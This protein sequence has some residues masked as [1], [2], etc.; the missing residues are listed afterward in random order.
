M[1]E[2]HRNKD[3]TLTAWFKVNAQSEACRDIL[4]QDFPSKMVWKDR[5]H[6]W[7]PREPGTFSISRMYH[8]HPTSGEHFYLRLLLTCTKGATSFEDLC[9]VDGVH[10]D[11][12]KEAC[13]LHGLVDDDREW[14]QCLTEA[15]DMAVGWQ[16]RHLFVSIL[17]DCTPSRPRELWDTFWPHICDDL[18]CQL[19]QWGMEHH[20]M[21]RCRTMASISLTNL[22]FTLVGGLRSGTGSRYL[23]ITL[24]WSRGTMT[25]MH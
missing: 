22:S 2:S 13:F 8:A 15:K 20:L 24:L 3:T 16:L 11:T 18:K 14:H 7:T 25:F 10:C 1:V 23:V 5:A 19:Q 9:T 21:N 12:F 6:K 17:H 4:Y